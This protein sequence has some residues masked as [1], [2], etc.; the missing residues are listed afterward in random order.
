VVWCGVVW[1]GLVRP[2]LTACKVGCWGPRL[3]ATDTATDSA[4]DSA[5]AAAGAA[6][7]WARL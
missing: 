5:A 1:S 7:C 6:A 4:T 2:S 3:A